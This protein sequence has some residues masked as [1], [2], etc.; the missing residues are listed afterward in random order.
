MGDGMGDSLEI[1]D[2][3]DVVDPE[4]AAKLAR[5]STHLPLV[6]RSGRGR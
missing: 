5:S 1:I 2:H 3:H 6:S 4:L